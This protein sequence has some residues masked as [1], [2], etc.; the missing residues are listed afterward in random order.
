MLPLPGFDSELWAAPAVALNQDGRVELLA[1]LFTGRV[2]RAF[3]TA[4]NSDSYS[5]MEELR[6]GRVFGRVAAIRNLAGKIE[7]FVVSGDRF[8]TSPLMHRWQHDPNT[9]DASRWSEWDNKG[10]DLASDPTAGANHDGRL[11]VFAVHTDGDVHRIFQRYFAFGGAPWSGWERLNRGPS[12]NGRFTGRVSVS[13]DGAGKMHVLARDTLGL[14]WMNNQTSPGG[15]WSGWS[16]AGFFSAG[17]PVIAT[18]SDGRLEMF[19]EGPRD[20]RIWHRWQTRVGG[21]WSGWQNLNPTSPM[22]PEVNSQPF[23][24]INGRGGFLHVFATYGGNL[25]HINQIHAFPYWTNW[26][27]LTAV[28]S[29]PSFGI[30]EYYGK[31]A[32]AA[33]PDGSIELFA[34]FGWW[35]GGGS[36]RSGYMRHTHLP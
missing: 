32:A 30:E 31:P 13:N 7:I 27:S 1:C 15:G 29:R 33:N 6:G 22:Q 34:T 21:G 11:E 20:H 2:H 25:V 14:V 4:L 26:S 19:V 10:G 5:S 17:D 12:F 24:V 36:G 18:N 28:R 8:P 3:Q 23:T 9:T 35:A 16:W